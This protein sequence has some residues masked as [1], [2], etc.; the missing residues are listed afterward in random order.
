MTFF[1]RKT[2]LFLIR[3][4]MGKVLIIIYLR[5]GYIGW[6]RELIIELDV[7]ERT[8]IRI[9]LYKLGNNFQLFWGILKIL[10]HSV[11]GH[12]LGGQKSEIHL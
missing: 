11:Q 7:K 12:F 1:A 3:Y 8:S 6:M 2:A 4:S 10:G 5:E 9:P